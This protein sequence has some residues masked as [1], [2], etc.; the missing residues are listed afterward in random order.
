MDPAAL[1]ME[2]RVRL[3]SDNYTAEAPVYEVTWAEGLR[4]M[5]SELLAEMGLSDPQSVLD[6]GAGVGALLDDIAELFPGAWVVGVDRAEGMIARAGSEHGRAVMD[7]SRLAFAEGSIDVA[8]MS[9]VL[10]HLP[11]PAVGLAEIHRILKPGGRFGVA[12]WGPDETWPAS[13]LWK[14]VLDE[15]GADEAAGVLSQH[16]LVDAPGKL[17]ALFGEAGF[18]DVRT[19]TRTLDRLFS[20]EEMIAFHEGVA[21][22]KRRLQS[23]D[24]ATRER[25]RSDVGERLRAVE[26]EAFRLQADVVCASASKG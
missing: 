3:L 24:P 5:G 22:S 8:V 2:E 16:D 13:E 26:P 21:V 9:F 7:A 20:P 6:V 23:L 12:T 4:T 17:Q 19:W 14:E 1:S 10:F 25:F 11:D 15:Y 18:E